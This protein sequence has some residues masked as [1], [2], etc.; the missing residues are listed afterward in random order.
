MR[1]VDIGDLQLAQFGHPQPRGI[2]RG[3]D[4][5]CFRLWDAV[6]KAATSA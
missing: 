5:R 6:S 1:A 4:A 3:E 2:E